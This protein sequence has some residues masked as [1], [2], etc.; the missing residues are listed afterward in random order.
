MADFTDSG[1]LFK[2]EHKM[3]GDNRPDYDGKINVGGVEKRLAA[4]I[5]DG[6]DGKKYMSLKVSDYQL[7]QQRQERPQGP[8]EKAAAAERS[9]P[10]KQGPLDD[11]DDSIPF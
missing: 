5:K 6:R 7:R 9:D 1:V 11:L 8:G 10:A 3:P 4:W 2:N